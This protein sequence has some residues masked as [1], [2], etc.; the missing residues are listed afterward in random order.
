MVWFRK[1]SEPKPELKRTVWVV[2]FWFSPSSNLN[3]TERAVRS[4]FT[5][6]HKPKPEPK[7]KL[8]ECKHEESEEIQT[9]KERCSQTGP[10][11]RAQVQSIIRDMIG[12][13]SF[14][15]EAL[16][17]MHRYIEYLGLHSIYKTESIY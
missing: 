16:A 6:I 9:C 1:I 4:R 17:C 5:D 14:T 3:Q 8:R 15:I 7:S 10:M 12:M 13:L 2:Q 11:D